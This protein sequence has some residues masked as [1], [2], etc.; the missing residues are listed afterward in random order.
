MPGNEEVV[1]LRITVD[2]GRCQGY[3]NC[4]MADAD[5]FDLDDDGLVVVLRDD[6]SA[7]EQA[8]AAEAARSCPAE[9]IRLVDDDG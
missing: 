5:H 6:V 7:G 2:V 4:V 3:G 8:D 1:L 9:A